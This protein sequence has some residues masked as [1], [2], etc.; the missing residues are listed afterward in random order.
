ML[1][2]NIFEVIQ[3]DVK[4]HSEFKVLGRGAQSMWL[5]TAEKCLK[6]QE[7]FSLVTYCFKT[8]EEPFSIM[9]FATGCKQKFLVVMH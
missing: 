5:A 7:Y 9:L 4:K 6:Y 8:T 1:G 3:A 2:S